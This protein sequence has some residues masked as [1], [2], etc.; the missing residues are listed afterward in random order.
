MQTIL[1]KGDGIIDVVGGGIVTPGVLVVRDSRIAAV[2]PEAD[3]APHQY[4]EIID[5][6]GQLLIAGN[7]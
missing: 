7:D 3:S 4:D 2:G 5:C 1:L 6:S